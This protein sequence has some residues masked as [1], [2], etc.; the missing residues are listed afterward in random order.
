VGGRWM[1]AHHMDW[2]LLNLAEAE[3]SRAGQRDEPQMVN[4]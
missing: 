3:A 1:L 2:D 4:G